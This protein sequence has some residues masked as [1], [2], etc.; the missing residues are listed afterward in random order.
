MTTTHL[1]IYLDGSKIAEALSTEKTT[2]TIG[3]VSGYS[4]TPLSL[5]MPLSVPEHSGVRV[6]NWLQGL[7]PDNDRVLASLRRLYR[8]NAKK[9]LSLLEKMG[10]DTPGALRFIPHDEVLDAEEGIEVLSDGEVAHLLKNEIDRYATGTNFVQPAHVSLAGAQPKLGLVQLS[11]GQWG[12]P[13]GVMPSTH[14][15]KPDPQGRFSRMDALEQ[16]AMRTARHMGLNVAESMMAELDG[17]KIYVTTRFDREIRGNKILRIHQ[18]DL[19]QTVGGHPSKKYNNE[20]G[21]GLSKI[22]DMLATFPYR[23]DTLRVGFELFRGILVNLLLRNSDAHSKNF[24]VL[25]EGDRVR[26]SPL[27][28]LMSTATLDVPQT[29]PF[30]IGDETAYSRITREG[31]LWAASVLHVPRDVALA[32]LQRQQNALAAAV[33]VARDEI[34]VADPRAREYVD[35]VIAALESFP[36]YE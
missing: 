20:G 10:S 25:L 15:L 27:Y 23:E 12:L 26:L 24:S 3:Y 34:I 19:L 8:V 32:E 14:I 9:P 11:N 30:Y 36:A 22:G 13:T 4:G 17:L 18:E 5:S 31:I 1:D 6:D 28:D 21:P 33:G 35:P 16:L 29:F 7:L 2:T